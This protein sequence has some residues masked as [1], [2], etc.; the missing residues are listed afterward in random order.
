MKKKI[1]LFTI[2]LTALFLGTTLSAAEDSFSI[3]GRVE[4][5]GSYF[6]VK[7]SEYLNVTLEST[8][9]IKVVLESIPE[10]ISLS[11]ET[12]REEINS[13][14][15]KIG[16]L[17]PNRTYYKYENGFENEAFFITDEN[18][19]Y[20]FYQEISQPTK[21]WI[22]GKKGSLLIPRQCEFP[23]GIWNRRNYDLYFNPRFDRQR[24]YPGE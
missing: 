9:A 12:P 6:K 15:L 4:G 17:E 14:I 11:V 10:I 22:L 3:P 19:S 8:A 13:T 1:I 24:Y 2:I 20:A 7:D 16:G 21:I 23:Y 5:T 18:G